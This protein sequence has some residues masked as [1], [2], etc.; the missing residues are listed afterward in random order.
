MAQETSAVLFL[1]PSLGAFEVLIRHDRW[2]WG[3]TED[4]SSVAG[5]SVE[6][7]RCERLELSFPAS[8]LDSVPR[9][10]RPFEH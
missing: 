7:R 4:E 1:A 3:T 10:L 9:D 2:E 8:R 6:R 5:K